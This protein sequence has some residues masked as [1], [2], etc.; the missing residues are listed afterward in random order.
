MHQNSLQAYSE[1]AQHLN[2]RQQAIL[3]FFQ[4]NPDS[5]YTD[6]QVQALMGFI[7]RNQVQPRITELIKLGKLWEVGRTKCPLTDKMVRTVGSAL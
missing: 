2:K 1:E 7:E 5:S 6:R 3:E 4:L